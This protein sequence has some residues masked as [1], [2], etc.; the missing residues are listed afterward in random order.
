MA[1]TI[2][3]AASPDAANFRTVLTYILPNAEEYGWLRIPWRND[4]WE[5]RRHAASE[6]KP[7]FLWGMN[8]NPLG[9]T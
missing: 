5:A 3:P 2:D 6:G 4:L 7:I 8:G 9:L 1:A